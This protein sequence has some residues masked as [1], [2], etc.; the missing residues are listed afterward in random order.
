MLL[1]TKLYYWIYFVLLP[2][3]FWQSNEG[4]IFNGKKGIS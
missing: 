4:N 3:S 1:P 2:A